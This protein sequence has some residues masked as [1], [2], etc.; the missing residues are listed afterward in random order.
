MLCAIMYLISLLIIFVLVGVFS[1]QNGGTQN[2]TFLGYTLNLY[3]WVP[4]V[5]GMAAM[6]ALLLLHMG[7]SGMG[8]R[9][10]QIGHGRALDEHRS[11]ID[12]LRTENGRLR[13]ELAAVRGEVRGAAGGPGGGGRASVLQGLRAFAGRDRPTT[14]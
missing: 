4:T 12:D 3:T 7:T 8:Y 6:T 2:F 11:V 10:R 9:L 14:S 13:E 1:V 5:L